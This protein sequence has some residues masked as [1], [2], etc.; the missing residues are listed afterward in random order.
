M[1]SRYFTVIHIANFVIGLPA[2]LTFVNHAVPIVAMNIVII[3]ILAALVNLVFV[4]SN[5]GSKT[6]PSPYKVAEN[7][8]LSWAITGLATAIY[9]LAVN[10]VIVPSLIILLVGLFT[11][12]FTSAIQYHIALLLSEDIEI[13]EINLSLRWQFNISLFVFFFFFGLLLTLIYS[14]ISIVQIILAAVLSFILSLI[15]SIFFFAPLLN[16]IRR[17]KNRVDE[18]ATR[19]GDISGRLFVR[20]NNE[21]GQL[22]SSINNLLDSIENIV[23]SLG[24]IS[25]EIS[26]R[27][28]ILS[29]ATEELNASL[30]EV[31]STV[32][33]IA[34]GSQEQSVGVSD[35][36]KALDEY[37]KFTASVTSQVKMTV[38][39]STKATKSAEEGLNLT[40]SAADISQDIYEHTLVSQE[41]MALLKKNA[42]EIKKIL[43]I[44]RSFSD[45]T[46]LLALN[47]AIE[48]ARLGE[49]GRGFA[50]VADEIR[51]LA[52]E[53]QKSSETVEVVIAETEKSIDELYKSLNIEQEKVVKGRDI[54]IRSEE[55]FSQIAKS[56]NLA[57]EMVKQIS[58]AAT[59][60]VESVRSLLHAIEDV[61]KVATDTASATEEVA[62]AVEEQTASMEELA[63]TAQA[64]S[65]TSIKLTELVKKFAKP[66]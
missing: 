47:S 37:S 32:Q 39:S 43:D 35:I 52:T 18:I 53:I 22:T 11:G 56:V 3:T 62:S 24:G 59:K 28:E 12:V 23:K 63:S 8:F 60:Q 46:D 34:K 61:A 33:H 25:F 30:E 27:A 2:F 40:K 26:E 9:L 36:A 54:N 50:V 57:N 15:L 5:R 66:S 65:Q 4:L 1:R 19:G 42:G 41:R 29:S 20:S 13:E 7:S 16:G 44:I 58:S 48:A 51:N 21:I 31:S 17:I 6:I 45:Q 49:A 64:L 38:V 14:R 55:Q 10:Q